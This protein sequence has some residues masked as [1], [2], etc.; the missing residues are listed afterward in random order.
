VSRAFHH[1]LDAGVACTVNELTQGVQLGELCLI[2]RIR[3]TARTQAVSKRVG[4][5]V[6]PHDCTDL[7]E[8]LVHG[9]LF[10]V[11]EHPFR[12]K[13]AAA[14][15]YARRAAFRQRHVLPQ[16]SRRVW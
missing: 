16:H 9:I 8:Q 3:E 10:S 2:R 15:D 5:I 6:L 1:R 12:E 7:V 14:R 4:D 13:R 11:D